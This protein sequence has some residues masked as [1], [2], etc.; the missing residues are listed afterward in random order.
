M[1]EIKMKE[2][3]MKEIKNESYYFQNKQK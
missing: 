3:K 1:K 2:I